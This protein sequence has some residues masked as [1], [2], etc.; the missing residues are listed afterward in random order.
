MI[1]ERDSRRITCL[2]EG[3]DECQSLRKIL[4]SNESLDNSFREEEEDHRP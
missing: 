1:R 4:G 2:L 3:S